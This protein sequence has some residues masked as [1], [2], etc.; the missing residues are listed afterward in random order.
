MRQLDEP[1]QLFGESKGERRERLRALIIEY[2]LTYG[3]SPDDDAFAHKIVDFTNL[4][5]T[6]EDIERANL[7]FDSEDD[8]LSGDDGAK[9]QKDEVFYTEGDKSLQEARLKIAKFSI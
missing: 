7:N 2:F 3:H 5:G 6:A 4:G 9:I 1:I 8:Y